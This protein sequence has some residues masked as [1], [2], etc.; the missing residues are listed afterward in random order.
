MPSGPFDL[1]RFCDAQGPVWITVR[2]ELVAGRKR[3]HWMWFVFPQLASLGR[4]A[5]AKFYGLGGAVF[6]DQCS[7][8][9]DTTILSSLACGADVMDHVLTQLPLALTA[10]GIGAVVAT[11]LAAVAL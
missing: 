8:I 1:E 5:T 9:S 7:P 3:S 11:A 2:A 4:S 10:A 6:G